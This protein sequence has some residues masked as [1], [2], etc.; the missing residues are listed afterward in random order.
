MLGVFSGTIIS[1]II[2]TTDNIACIHI[3]WPL[4]VFLSNIIVLINTEALNP[5]K[6]LK[7][8]KEPVSIQQM[9][10]GAVLDCNEIIHFMTWLYK[11]D[12]HL[13]LPWLTELGR[14]TV[15]AA[16]VVFDGESPRTHRARVKA[17]WM[18]RF[19]LAETE[20]IVHVDRMNAEGVMEYVASAAH[21]ITGKPLTLQ[22]YNG[23]RSAVHHL[24]RCHNG[25]G[26]GEEYL[27]D[28]STLWSGFHR[29]NN[30]L[31]RKKLEN[32]TENANGDDGDN[33]SDDEDD[34]DDFKEA[35]YRAAPT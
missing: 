35:N 11:R 21:H 15:D 12:N 30:L 2:L 22:G 19:R 23:K 17:A 34:S 28:I 4:V 13:E 8:L 24:I 9:Q 7:T 6:R 5:P 10:D 26:P 33:N 20:P 31:K 14:Q 1:N 18:E 16:E 29:H 32:D 27:Q 25:I 3:L